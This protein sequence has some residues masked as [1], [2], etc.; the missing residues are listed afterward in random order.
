MTPEMMQWAQRWGVSSHALCELREMFG[1]D[2]AVGLPSRGAG[3]SEASVQAAVRLAEAQRGCVLWRNNV[4]A[5]GPVRYG[6]ANDSARVNARVKSSDLI[7]IRPTVITPDMVGT[8]IGRF[9]ARECK[10]AGWA[11]RGDPRERAQLRYI[12]IVSA[13]G[14]DAKFVSDAEQSDAP[15]Q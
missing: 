14:G 15:G 4:G 12:E 3:A 7:G 5:V 9:V 1:T 2:A 8:L 6:L 11:Y 13:L 10:R